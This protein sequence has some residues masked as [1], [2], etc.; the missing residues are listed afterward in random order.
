MQQLGT[1]RTPEDLPPFY[2]WM[3]QM[4]EQ[5]L[6]WRQQEQAFILWHLFCYDDVKA[7]LTDYSRFSSALVVV[8]EETFHP[9]ANSLV[10]MDPPRHRQYRTLVSQTFTPRAIA[11]L[12]PRIRQIAQD[13][14]DK[15]Q[16]QGQMDLVRDF[17]YPFTLTVITEML[18]I[19]ISEQEQVKQASDALVAGRPEVTGSQEGLIQG[20]IAYFAH[21]LDER[22]K[23]L[24]DDLLSALVQAE[25]DGE[26]LSEYDIINFCL[27]LLIAGHET[28]THLLSHAMLCLDENPDMA[29]QL[30]AD[31]S[32]IDNTIEEVLRYRPST[33]G[34]YRKTLTEVEI[35]GQQ[36][37]AGQL[38]FT[39]LASANRDPRHFADPERFDIRR[40]PEQHLAF[41]SGIHFCLG[42]PLARLEAS[43][44]LPMLLEQLPELARIPDQPVEFQKSVNVF[45]IAR[46][47]MTFVP[48]SQ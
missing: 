30:R 18:G 40:T 2:A 7:V 6:V 27:L 5:Q 41:G 34:I 48:P 16:S 19:S 31:P 25:V 35:G 4:R 21:L 23:S 47:P 11:R 44:A 45:G 9:F 26:K 15:V 38:I 29:E 28:T 46:F 24:Q 39:W 32:L 36:I 22:R 13:L 43:I 17:T 20:L 1:L 37:P 10:G 12:A 14:L 42:A 33:W 8:P 3:T